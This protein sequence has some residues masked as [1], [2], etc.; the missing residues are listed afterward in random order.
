MSKAF[1]NSGIE[2]GYGSLATQNF[3]LNQ[4][5]YINRLGRVTG[6][7]TAKH[8]QQ[9]LGIGPAVKELPKPFPKGTH[10]QELKAILLQFEQATGPAFFGT[11][12]RCEILRTAGLLEMTKPPTAMRS[13]DGGKGYGIGAEYILTDAGRDYIRAL[14]A[15]GR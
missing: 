1:R 7:K 8:H 11:W 6:E 14:K 13:C 15:K 12:S 4:R 9:C 10:V 3:W 5:R 2:G